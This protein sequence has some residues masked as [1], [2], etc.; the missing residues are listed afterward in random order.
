MINVKRYFQQAE[1]GL[2]QR[3]AAGERVLLILACW[4][5]MIARSRAIPGGHLL[6]SVYRY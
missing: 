3:L 4:R 6:A 5:S 1:D 2:R